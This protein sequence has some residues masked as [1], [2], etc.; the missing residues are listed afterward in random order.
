MSRRRF[1]QTLSAATGT[2]VLGTIGW[3]P[4]AH[5]AKTTI[6]FFN[7]ETDP[8]TIAFLK[9]VAQ[10]Y[11]EEAGVKIQIENVPVLQTWT[12]VTTAIVF[13]CGTSCSQ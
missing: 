11:Q 9:Q 5:A 3:V 10:E 1:L 6:R 2:A 4:R 13:H 7:N 8:N 12:K